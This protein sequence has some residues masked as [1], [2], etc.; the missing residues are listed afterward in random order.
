M[1]NLFIQYC[2]FLILQFKFEFEISEIRFTF[3][4]KSR[5]LSLNILSIYLFPRIFKKIL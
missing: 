2:S 4:T 1:L 5:Q 3:R